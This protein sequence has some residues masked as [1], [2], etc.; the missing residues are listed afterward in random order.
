MKNN[1]Y[2]IKKI[3]DN[4][5]EMLFIN[6]KFFYKQKFNYFKSD[7]TPFLTKVFLG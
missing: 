6:K 3:N 5:K 4:I 1:F 2:Y 7:L